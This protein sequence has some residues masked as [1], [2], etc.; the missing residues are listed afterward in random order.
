MSKKQAKLTNKVANIVALF[1]SKN[2]K[3]FDNIS[4]SH[5]VNKIITPIRSVRDSCINYTSA[6]KF[7]SNDKEN[8]SYCPLFNSKLRPSR[9]TSFIQNSNKQEMSLNKVQIDSKNSHIEEKSPYCP[10]YNSKLRPSRTTSFIGNS[11]NNHNLSLNKL[12]VE[13]PNNLIKSKALKYVD[14]SSSCE[15]TP[16]ITPRSSNEEVNNF[17]IFK[18][19]LNNFIIHRHL[20]LKNI[21]VIKTLCKIEVGQ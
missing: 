20:D 19:I 8:S 12:H 6:T 21:Q 5:S 3:N 9:T 2:D 18:T 17:F 14:S 16:S 15:T 4:K 13:T 10:L 11:T 7:G 1:E